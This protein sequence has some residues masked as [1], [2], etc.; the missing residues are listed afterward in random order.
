V[1]NVLEKE[2]LESILLA[3]WTN[4]INTQQ[5]VRLTL[6]VIRDAIYPARE[7]AS[8][9]GP[10]PKGIRVS[11]TNV[12]LTDRGLEIWAEFNAAT[13]MGTVIGTHIFC[14]DL[15]GSFSLKETYGTCFS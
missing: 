10:L 2:K 11:V 6:E 8:F 4:Y 1:Q 9:G 13:A 5:L 14:S 15:N 3:N 7:A 12:G